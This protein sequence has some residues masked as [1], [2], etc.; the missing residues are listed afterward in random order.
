MN[1]SIS[2]VI[3]QQYFEK[4]AN[5]VY[6]DIANFVTILTFSHCQINFCGVFI[7]QLKLNNPKTTLSAPEIEPGFA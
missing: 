2:F 7:I 5:Q 6:N 3:S 1:I 4:I